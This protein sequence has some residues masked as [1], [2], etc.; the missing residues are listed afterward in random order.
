MRWKRARLLLLNF[1]PG[2]IVS[3]APFRES[4]LETVSITSLSAKDFSRWKEG[5]ALAILDTADLSLFPCDTRS[6]ASRASRSLA[7]RFHPDISR[8]PTGNLFTESFLH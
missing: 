3:T 5:A 4:S 7:T 2:N 1:S 6:R 8:L